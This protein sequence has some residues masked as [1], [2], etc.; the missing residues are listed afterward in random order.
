[1]LDVDCA[2]DYCGSCHG[3]QRTLDGRGWYC[4]VY[5]RNWVGPTATRVEECLQGSFDEFV[6]SFLREAFRIRRERGQQF[7]L[8]DS[9]FDVH[10][11][12]GMFW[13]CALQSTGKNFEFD[14][15]LVFLFLA[16]LKFNRIFLHRRNRSS[17]KD[18]YLDLF[19]YL[20]FAA[21]VAEEE[22]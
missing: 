14:V 10:E 2:D 15:E 7:S 12:L 16:L 5:S 22:K 21:E 1:M 17:S 13:S 18:S 4:K 11:T 6:G 8:H 3:L 19:N 9:P 20:L